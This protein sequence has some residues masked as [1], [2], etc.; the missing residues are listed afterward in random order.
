[1]DW[2]FCNW[3]SVGM[4]LEK[5]IFWGLNRNICEGKLAHW[6]NWDWDNYCIHNFKNYN[7]E[8]FR[9]YLLILIVDNYNKVFYCD[10]NILDFW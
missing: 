3:I 8:Y 1:M 10:V 6:S 9:Y 4:I 2:G 5:R 7:L